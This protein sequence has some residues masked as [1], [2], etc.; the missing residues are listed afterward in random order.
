MQRC[1]ECGS[2]VKDINELHTRPRSRLTFGLAFVVA[3]AGLLT[4][5]VLPKVALLGPWG[6]VPNAILIRLAPLSLGKQGSLELVRRIEGGELSK[7]HRM[8]VLENCDS[9]L[10]GGAAE[11]DQLDSIGVVLVIERSGDQRAWDIIRKAMRH[12]RPSVWFAAIDH[13]CLSS[14]VHKPEWLVEELCDVLAASGSGDRRVWALMCLKTLSI[15]GKERIATESVLQAIRSKDK[16]VALLTAMLYRYST[17]PENEIKD[18]LRGMLSDP[19]PSI[20][21]MAEY[22]LEMDPKLLNEIQEEIRT[23]NCTE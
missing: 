21:R 1:P 13:C 18:G 2:T 16:N 23:C 11:A 10:A 15:S 22:A 20:R 5:T 8:V 12:Q 17:L 4:A 7:Q 14:S 9:V 3:I 19:D 6:A